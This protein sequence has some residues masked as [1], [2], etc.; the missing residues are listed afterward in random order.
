VTSDDPRIKN[1]AK[2][3]DKPHPPMFFVSVASKRLSLGVSPLFATPADC[4]AGVDLK[5]VGTWALDCLGPFPPSPPFLQEID[6]TGFSGWG[7]DKSVRGKNL[8]ANRLGAE[9]NVEIGGLRREWRLTIMQ[10]IITKYRTCQLK[11]ESG[12]D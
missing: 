9:R 10:Y 4:R 1:E 6:A 12:L 5:G 3:E 8:G 7:S 2:N 11:F